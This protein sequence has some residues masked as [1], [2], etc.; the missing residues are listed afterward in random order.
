MQPDYRFSL[1]M[2]SASVSAALTA[3]D[4]A[5]TDYGGVLA[6]LAQPGRTPDEEAEIFASASPSEQEVVNVAAFEAFAVTL[7][8]RGFPRPRYDQQKDH[9]QEIVERV[10]AF[11]G[12]ALDTEFHI[13]HS[14]E[15]EGEAVFRD[16]RHELLLTRKIPLPILFMDGRASHRQTGA[17]IVIPSSTGSYLQF[18]AMPTEKARYLYSPVPGSETLDI[19][20]K[21]V[22]SGFRRSTS[23]PDRRVE[24]LL[25]DRQSAENLIS[26]HRESDI[27][28]SVSLSALA[29]PDWR[30]QWLSSPGFITRLLVLI[31]DDPINL[32]Q[33]LAGGGEKVQLAAA[34]AM[35]HTEPPERVEILCVTAEGQPNILY[36]TPVSAP[37]RQSI[38]EVALRR[39]GGAQFDSSFLEK[40]T[41]LLAR[42]TP[43]LL[44]EEGAFGTQ[45]W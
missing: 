37:H 27:I 24:F 13:P 6:A 32:V 23:P 34:T 14:E 33:W 45:F 10:K 2:T 39:I 44:Q 25:T 5:I 41:P 42:V 28:A 17:E 18:V 12:P 31:D 8:N 43:H 38:V 26:N 19:W 3:I 16:F 9:L 20:E 36:Y 1:L 7:A 30:A 35:F 11:A 4:Q 29:D 22:V 21:S 15:E 40:W